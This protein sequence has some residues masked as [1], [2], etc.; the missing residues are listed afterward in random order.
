M[1]SKVEDSTTRIPLAPSNAVSIASALP[2]SK[3]QIEERSSQ[4]EVV[5]THTTKSSNESVGRVKRE[6]IVEEETKGGETEEENDYAEE[7]DEHS[8]LNQPPELILS[9]DKNAFEIFQ[10][11]L[12]DQKHTIDEKDS[13]WLKKG[14]KND[15]GGKQLLK[16]PFN[17]YSRDMWS[18]QRGNNERGPLQT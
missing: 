1:R 18:F 7:Q 12:G 9:G 17:I 10:E 2:K 5:I 8:D 4:H 15:L 13:K 14:V 3:V 16:D 6:P 11:Y